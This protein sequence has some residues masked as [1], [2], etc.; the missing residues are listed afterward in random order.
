L[1]GRGDVQFLDVLAKV[2]LA[3]ASEDDILSSHQQADARVV[4]GSVRVGMTTAFAEE[5]IT[6]MRSLAMQVG[7]VIALAGSLV[8]AAVIG[9]L[10]RPLS[11][12][13][14]GNARV[15]RGDFSLRLQ[16]RSIDEF[17]RLASSYN[18][19][20]DE[21]ER[22]RELA[23]RYL[24]SLRRSA[25]E[26]E[27]ANKALRQNNAEITKASRMKSE[28]LAVMSHELRTPLNGIIGFS[29]VLL[30]EKFGKLNEKQRRFIENTL[31][32]GRHLLTL[33]NDILDLSKVE[34]GRMEITPEEF[35]LHQCVDDIH[36]L[37]RNLAAKK[38]VELAC[39][40]VP[41]VT[42]HTDPKLLRQILLNLLSNAIKFTTEGGKVELVMRTMHGRQLRTEPMSRA[43]PPGGRDAVP[44]EDLLV[45]EVSD[46][47]I[48]IAPEDYARIFTA[49]EQLDTA[50]S[51]HQEGTGLGLALTRRIVRLLRGDI[52]FTSRQNEGS[53]FMFYVPLDFAAGE[54]E[55]ITRQAFSAADWSTQT[56]AAAPAAAPRR[57]PRARG[58]K[59][60]VVPAPPEPA[61]A[62][63]WPWGEGRD[64]ATSSRPDAPRVGEPQLS[65]RGDDT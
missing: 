13:M 60:R 44:N 10:T 32:S 2:T 4:L 1:R 63:V 34:S 24:E 14:E 25:E 64:A 30:D 33:I 43:M 28:F 42:P 37:V 57:A 62:A 36:T 48:G 49:F 31:K 18:Q 3:K 55:E 51:R 59:R 53:R 35:E 12:L 47:G 11:K 22:S 19:M 61:P 65:S 20:A 9:W 27:E 56:T 7:L 23:N 21:I 40:Q 38:S 26:L 8:A 41:R 45:V 29:E 54:R 39:S 15:A 50:Y 58:A 5:R 6:A 46:T 16:V 52:W 17:G